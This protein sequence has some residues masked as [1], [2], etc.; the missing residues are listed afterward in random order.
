MPKNKGDQPAGITQD[1]LL[2]LLAHSGRPDFTKRRLTQFTSKELL[3]P[4]RRIPRIGSNWPVYV[5]EQG[6]IEQAMDLYDVIELGNGQYH[7]LLLALWLRGY[8]VPF[9]PLLQRWIR[10]IEAFLHSLTQGEH[11]PD[12]ILDHISSIMVDIEPKWKF[13][14]QPDYVIRDIGIA[15]WGEFMEFILAL[16]VIPTYEPD[17]MSCENQLTTLQNLHKIAQAN[18]HRGEDAS[19]QASRV[20]AEETLSWLLSYRDVV[21][22]PRLRDTLMNARSEEWA[23]ARNDYLALCQLL[24]DFAELFPHR[25]ARMTPQMREGMF[26]YYGFLLPPLFLSIRD[27]GYGEQVSDMLAGLNDVLNMFAGPDF[28]T[29]LAKM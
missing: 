21:T 23:Q 26:L 19:P 24:H 17:E 18:A 8:D 29:L 5:W 13:S 27:C 22:L 25:N 15:T 7:R 1:E 2:M 4:L 6:V 10:I 3:P 12:A 28:C 9:A 11:D 14:P 16:F 20:V